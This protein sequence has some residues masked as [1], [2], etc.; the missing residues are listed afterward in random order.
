MK[1][2]FTKKTMPTPPCTPP[3]TAKEREAEAEWHRRF[4]A[5]KQEAMRQQAE[6]NE[7]L[8]QLPKAPPVPTELQQLNMRL[9]KL[10]GLP[11]D[12]DREVQRMV[13]GMPSVP[14]T[15]VR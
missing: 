1:T 15:R 10:R 6:A 8:A 11:P 3:M 4:Q 5:A 7:L 2:W 12:T 9:N 13:A 14:T